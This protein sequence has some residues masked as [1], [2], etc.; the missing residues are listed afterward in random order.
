[1]DLEGIAVGS[2]I[3]SVDGRSGEITMRAEEAYKKRL[4]KLVD[5]MVVSVG[6]SKGSEDNW[7]AL[8]ALRGP[9]YTF[10]MNAIEAAAAGLTEAEGKV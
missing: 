8:R 3:K 9:D 7:N 10:A 1:M 6:E 4:R 5:V 2:G